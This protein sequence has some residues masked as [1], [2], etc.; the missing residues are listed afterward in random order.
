M[1]RLVVLGVWQFFLCTLYFEEHL[2]DAF[3]SQTMYHQKVISWDFP[4]SLLLGILGEVCSVKKQLFH[5]RGVPLGSHQIPASVPP[6]PLLTPVF[7]IFPSIF[8]SDFSFIHD[9][10]CKYCAFSL[11][12]DL[13]SKAKPWWHSRGKYWGN[14]Q[15]KMETIYKETLQAWKHSFHS[16]GQC[17]NMPG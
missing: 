13:K 17:T 15:G 9:V 11:I 8:F 10:L 6:C 14:D 3:L 7:C 4:P 5:S 12:S 16:S 2:V 1:V